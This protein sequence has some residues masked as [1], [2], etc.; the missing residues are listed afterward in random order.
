[1]N[2]SQK[3]FFNEQIYNRN[4]IGSGFFSNCYPH[5]STTVIVTTNSLHNGFVKLLTGIALNKY[6]QAQYGLNY[7]MG[8]KF[9]NGCFQFLVR[10]L[11]TRFNHYYYADELEDMFHNHELG[12]LYK[13]TFYPYMNSD[14]QE[15][16][17]TTWLDAKME[18]VGYYRGTMVL[19]DSIPSVDYDK[20]SYD[21][22]T[23]LCDVNSIPYGSI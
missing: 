1:M 7:L 13:E 21:K 8:I 22:F 9:R 18:N 2:Q 17:E 12:T 11:S 23:S 19:F 3:R 20:I 10:K 15:E 4:C 5:S 14:H 6:F 16:I